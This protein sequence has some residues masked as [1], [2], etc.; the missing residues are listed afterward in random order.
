MGK[1]PLNRLNQMQAGLAFAFIVAIGLGFGF[2]STSLEVSSLLFGLC[3][4]LLLAM[5]L[6]A[7]IGYAAQ[8][9]IEAVESSDVVG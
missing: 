4:T 3:G 9:I 1:T 6:T 2:M 5:I 8:A 7:A